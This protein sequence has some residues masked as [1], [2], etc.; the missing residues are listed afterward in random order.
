MIM[1]NIDKLKNF[2][3]DGSTCAVITSD[4]NRRYF[5]GMK[6]SAGVVICFKEKAYLI[7]DFRYFEKAS[8]KVQGLEVIL[9]KDRT[10]QI[11]ELFRIHGTRT[12]MIEADT[13][14]VSQLN[15]FRQ[16]FPKIST[17][18]SA[19]LSNAISEMRLVKTDNELEKIRQAQKITDDTFSYVLENIHDGMTE[20][21]LAL[22]MDCNMK[23]NGAEDISFDTIALFGKNTSLPHGVPGDTV[24]TGN[25]FVLMDFGAIVDGLHSDMTRTIFFGKP[26][27]EEMKVYNTVL[28][29]QL[30]ALGVIGP[31]V[32][33]RDIDGQ[34][35]DFTDHCGYRGAFGHSL[36]HGVGFEIHEK[37][38]VSRRNDFILRNG[39][40]VTVEPG[41]Y[42]P[43]KFGVRI[44][45]MV[46]ITDKSYENI[47]HS[48]KD[49]III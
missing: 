20:K 33:C 15:S 29:A 49:L 32:N 42:L 40:V 28:D 7:I 12:A 11:S 13:M 46:F 44:E 6:S 24:I 1:T 23:K 4:I 31:G 18:F 37:P 48:P 22:M 21:D 36:G 25:G 8:E 30:N 16:S 27:E 26:S 10:V 17:D 34:I 19:S 39:H 14:T 2:L 3:P 5:T 43:G 45:D 41:I 35:H 47:T 9:E 38:A